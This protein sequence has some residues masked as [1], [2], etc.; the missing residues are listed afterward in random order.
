MII[1]SNH[2]HIRLNGRVCVVLF[3]GAH[4]AQTWK[5]V[6]NCN[7]RELF[8]TQ[9]YRRR[10]WGCF[11]V[12]GLS[13]SLSN[14]MKKGGGRNQRTKVANTH[15]GRQ[16]TNTIATKAQNYERTIKKNG[17][18]KKDVILYMYTVQKDVGVRSVR[19]GQRYTAAL[20]CRVRLIGR[21]SKGPPA[22]N[23]TRILGVEIL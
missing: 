1:H 4:I 2:I 5:K 9:I 22:L 20:R 16:N 10:A 11:W 19:T 17:K 15:S 18:L 21:R 6:E 3:Y 14:T 13:L 8:C 12:C 7:T 23:S